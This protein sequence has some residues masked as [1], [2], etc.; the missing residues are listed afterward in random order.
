MHIASAY[1]DYN[2]DGTLTAAEHRQVT[3]QEQGH[4]MGMGHNSSTGSCM[5]GTVL[6]TGTPQVPDS[7][8]YGEL[9]YQIYNH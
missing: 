1:I 2:D 5:Y 9:Q 4:A 8:D 6:P 3:C 7:D